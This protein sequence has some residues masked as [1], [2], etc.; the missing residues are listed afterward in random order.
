MEGHTLLCGSKQGAVPVP[1]LPFLRHESALRVDHGRHFEI[2]T[3]SNQ[4]TGP[5][6]GVGLRDAT[7]SLKYDSLTMGEIIIH[8]SF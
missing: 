5:I 7:Q 8:F 4:G 3:V 6:G 1:T 2:N